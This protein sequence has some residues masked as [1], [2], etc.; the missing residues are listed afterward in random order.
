MKKD[1]IQTRKM[2]YD[3]LR[4]IACI[5]VVMLHVS[6]FY[7]TKLSPESPEWRALNFYDSLTRSS[8]PLFFM[9]SGVFMLSKEQTIK[10]LYRKNILHLIIVFLIWSVLYAVD[11]IGIPA[12]FQSDWNKILTFVINGKYHLW[13]LPTMISVYIVIPILHPL[14]D[15]CNGKYLW[16]FVGA[17]FVF[18]V[19]KA[20]LLLYPYSNTS[21][22]TLLVDKIPDFRFYTGYFVLGYLLA[23]KFEKQINNFFLVLSASF[24]FSGSTY[25][26]RLDAIAKQVPA[27]LFYGYFCLPV[28]LEAI[29]LFLLL[30]NSEDLLAKTTCLNRG[31]LFFSRKT[32]GIYLLHPFVLERL[33]RIGIN[34]LTW[35]SWITVPIVTGITVLICLVISAV[36]SQIP[37][38]RKCL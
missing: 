4:S 23:N 16:Y 18:G 19:V 21:I 1:T 10:R 14:V 6:A 35:N 36:L 33:D 3:L 9:I 11:A 25:I 31:I 26:G 8:V 28:C 30:K 22:F 12:F 15:Y 2:Q 17:F 32:M 38:V 37:L 13:F 7:W 5:M 20:T 34:S 29:C 24:I 27:G